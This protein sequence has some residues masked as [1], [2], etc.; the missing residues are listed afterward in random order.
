MLWRR[1]V[2]FTFDACKGF[3]LGLAQ[4]YLPLF[5]VDPSRLAMLPVL[6]IRGV[7]AVFALCQT[8]VSAPKQGKEFLR[9][10]LSYAG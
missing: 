9:E 1:S 7:C 10:P 2:S 5:G 3:F 4:E 6:S 8:G